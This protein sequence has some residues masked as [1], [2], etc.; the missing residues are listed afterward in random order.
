MIEDLRTPNNF[1]GKQARKQKKA[2]LLELTALLS[3]QN[4]RLNQRTRPSPNLI[5]DKRL[6]L[7]SLWATG[8]MGQEESWDIHFDNPTYF[9]QSF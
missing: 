9:L 3:Y 8:D 2:C 6:E 1:R 5:L 4:A 7:P